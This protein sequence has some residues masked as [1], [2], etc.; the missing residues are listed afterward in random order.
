[1]HWEVGGDQKKVKVCP[2]SAVVH[3]SIAPSPTHDADWCSI[4][5]MDG[6]TPPHPHHSYILHVSTSPDKLHVQ[7]AAIANNGP[8]RTSSAVWWVGG[9][10]M[11]KKETWSNGSVTP[12]TVATQASVRRGTCG[13]YCS[14]HHLITLHHTGESS[15]GAADDICL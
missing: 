9:K 4:M 6:D 5:W 10:K 14:H 1:M 13:E 12:G 3:P 2:H 8:G 15:S 11:K 7:K